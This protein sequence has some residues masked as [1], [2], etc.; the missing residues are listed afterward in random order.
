MLLT[1]DIGNTNIKTG[2]FSNDILIEMMQFNNIESFSSYIQ[3]ISVEHIAVSSVVPDL[4][5]RISDLSQNIKGITPFIITKDAGFNLEIAYNSPE[6]LGIDRLCSAEGAFYLYKNSED[7]KS[8][9][10]GTCILSIDFGTATTINIV[11]FPGRFVG[12][13]IAPGITMMFES[14]DSRTA[15]LPGVSEKYYDGFIGNNTASSIASGV[16][17]SAAGLI[18]STVNYLTAEMKAEDL[19]IFITGGN[20]EKLI[21]YLNFEY[22]YIPEL[23][24]IGVRTVYKM[25]FPGS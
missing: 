1:C 12:G 9:N 17:N 22:N 15:Q 7:Y 24:L 20:A 4:T 18:K 21:P 16:I 6:T 25:N 23:V 8:F 3:S 5:Q 11:R 10:S 14:L 13:I 2:L 19:K